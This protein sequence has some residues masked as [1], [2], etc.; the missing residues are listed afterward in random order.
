MAAARE[1]FGEKGY[2]DTS[3]AEIAR[4]V[5]IVEGAVYRHFPSKRDLLHQVIRSFYEP[6][7]ESA[8]RGAA[9]IESP[10]DRLRF[11]IRRGLQA[12]TDDRL[13]CRLI[14]SEAR[15]LD[16]Y[17]ESDIADL[18]RRYTS[19]AVETV[20][21][22]V[23]AGWYRPDTNPQMVR[24]L[25]YGGI[26]HLAWGTITGRGEFDLESMVR[27]LADLVL[28]GITNRPPAPSNPADTTSRLEVVADRLE[29][30]LPTS[31]NQPTPEQP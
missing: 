26:E 30:L 8:T 5:G 12:L 31:S 28:G 20:R 11:L 15:T 24:D 1:A 29:K 17:Y 10:D 22:G 16:D 7:V 4:R 9:A 3:V 25:I 27:Q 18:S 2:D 23:D 21:E 19:L 14:I 13:V 6:L